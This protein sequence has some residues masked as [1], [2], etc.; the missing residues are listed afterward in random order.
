MSLPE[1][2]VPDFEV[3]TEGDMHSPDYQMELWIPVV[4]I[5]TTRQTGGLY[6]GYK[7]R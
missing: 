3:Y 7:P 5:M 1:S 2:G 6:Q 4:K